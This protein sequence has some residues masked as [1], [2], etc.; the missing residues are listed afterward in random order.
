MSEK[1]K[2]KPVIT[3]EVDPE[4]KAELEALAA[5]HKQLLAPYARL[6]LSERLEME[7]AKA[8]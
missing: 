3:I 7:K 8:A 1:P 6:I 2:R 4:F 5:K